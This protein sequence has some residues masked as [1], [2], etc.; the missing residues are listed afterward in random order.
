[1]EAEQLRR[2]RIV[3]YIVLCAILAAMAVTLGV[4]AG[5][6]AGRACHNDPARQK[7]FYYLAGTLLVLLVLV[8][9][10]MA[11]MLLRLIAD[12]ARLRETGRSET[13]YVNAWQEAGKRYQLAGDEK[14]DQDDHDDKTLDD[15]EED[16][17]L[18][19]R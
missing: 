9:M 12:V 14:A 2:S 5:F 13:P 10:A 19:G 7:Y 17:P 4:L 18:G 15:D 1:M 16:P 11:L 3:R 6:A 8:A